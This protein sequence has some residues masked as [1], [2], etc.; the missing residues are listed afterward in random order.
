MYLRGK[1]H[2][3][4]IVNDIKLAPYQPSTN[5]SPTHNTFT[6]KKSIEVIIEKYQHPGIS[7]NDQILIYDKPLRKTNYKP[8]RRKA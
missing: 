6:R 2:T 1:K 4:P 8:Q 3:L 7:I 5:Q